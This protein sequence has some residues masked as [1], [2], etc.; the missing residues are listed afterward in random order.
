MNYSEIIAQCLKT[1]T[2][3]ELENYLNELFKDYS[4]VE[5]EEA[6]NQFKIKVWEVVSESDLED[7]VTD[8]ISFSSTETDEA[9]IEFASHLKRP[10]DVYAGIL[11]WIHKAVTHKGNTR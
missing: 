3:R 2:K 5:D 9:E 10:E 11:H 7:E 8:Y 1:K 6:M 4:F